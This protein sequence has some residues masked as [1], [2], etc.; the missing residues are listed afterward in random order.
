MGS[1][2]LFKKQKARSA[3]QLARQRI[4]RSSGVR[5]LIVCEGTK[6]EPQYFAEILVDKRIHPQ[7]VK[8]ARNDG[9]SPDRI[10]EHALNIYE[11]DA[12]LGD[13]YDKVFCVFDRD[14]HASFEPAIQRIR[15]LAKDEKPFSAITSTPCFEFWILLHFGYSDAPFH[16]AG[17]K[18]VG[19]QAVAQL[20]RKPKFS[21]Y[22]KGMKGVYGLLKD[23]TANACGHAKKLRKSAE[24]DSQRSANP[25]TNLDELV[26]LL[27]DLK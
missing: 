12:K 4:K 15:Q 17:K 3:E 18:S 21:K 5:Y 9:S 8:V 11:E 2:D 26:L 24:G 25:W 16:A 19:D 6:T 7:R 20:K 22:E 1:D 23:T 27:L 14:S 13:A 10:V